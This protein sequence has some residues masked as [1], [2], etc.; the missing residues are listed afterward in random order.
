VRVIVEGEERVAVAEEVARRLARRE[1][2]APWS[3]RS[4]DQ[5]NPTV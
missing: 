2:R 5:P 4:P 1:P 3:R